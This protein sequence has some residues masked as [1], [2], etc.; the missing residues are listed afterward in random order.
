VTSDGNKRVISQDN[1]NYTLIY[2]FVTL[3]MILRES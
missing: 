1:K 2:M 3:T